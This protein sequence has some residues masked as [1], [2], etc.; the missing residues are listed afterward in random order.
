MESAPGG[1]GQ[2]P[3]GW[4]LSPVG[5]SQAPGGCGLPRVGGVRLRVG[6]VCSWWVESSPGGG[7]KIPARCGGQGQSRE[8]ISEMLLAPPPAVPV[9]RQAS[10]AEGVVRGS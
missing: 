8:M 7:V 6:G 5:K 4:G 2:A 10:W 3:G 1:R 9:T